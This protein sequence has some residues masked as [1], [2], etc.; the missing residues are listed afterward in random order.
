MAS[1][2]AIQ[3]AR[4]IAAEKHITIPELAAALGEDPVHVGN[5]LRGR[6]YPSQRIR[7]GLPALLGRPIEELFEADRL[8]MPY[9]G[10]RGR[11]GG[12][13]KRVTS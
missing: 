12:M 6:A 9:G 8:A 10:P 5:A 2:Y 4:S 7:D 1:R 3:P 13:R 11:N